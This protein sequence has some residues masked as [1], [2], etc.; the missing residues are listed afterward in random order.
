MTTIYLDQTMWAGRA[1]GEDTGLNLPERRECARPENNVV[2]FT[3]WK[4]ENTAWFE[5]G[6]E[7]PASGLGDYQGRELVRRPRDRYAAL[8][9]R[10]ELAATLS[11]VCAMAALVLRVL[12]F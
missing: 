8:L 10:G 12:L 1:V 7:E 5:E 2:D 9:A 6:P 4:A 3:A 11:V